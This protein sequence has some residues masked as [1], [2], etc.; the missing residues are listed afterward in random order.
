MSKPR[1]S[2]F[3]AGFRELLR[4]ILRRAPRLRGGRDQRLRTRRRVA[5]HGGTFAGHRAYSEGE[6]LRHIDWNVYARTGDMFLKVF[7][8]EDR[9]SL[10]LCL[11]CSASMTTGEPER[12]RGAL[13]L[14]AILGG[15]ALVRLD[16]VEVVAGTDRRA[17]FESPAALP[18]LLAQLER[19]EIEAQDPVAL[20]RAGIEGAGGAIC[21]LSDFAEPERVRPA[22]AMVRRFGRR[23]SG[24][25]PTLATD[26]LPA[27]DG[28]VRLR[29]PE[30]GEE[31]RIWVDAPLRR[32]MADELTLL[33]RQQDAVFAEFGL[34][35]VR[36]PLP[37]EHDYRMSSW[38]D[39]VWAKR[40]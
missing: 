23:C 25:L 31:E 35:L 38:F 34:P 2:P 40:L 19:E 37:A 20:L 32:A 30:T 1:S 10:T 3:D 12:W 13:R 24:W 14:A 27:V 11:D 6:D 28:W 8:E 18:R 17:R 7:E 33:A 22:L 26:R 15:M 39:A 5:A 36:L 16:G 21:W 9:R 4:Q 29:D